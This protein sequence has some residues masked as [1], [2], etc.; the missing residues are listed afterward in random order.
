MKIKIEQ[1]ALCVVLVAGEME[2]K[3]QSKMKKNQR[4]TSTNN[5][6]LKCYVNKHQLVS[7]I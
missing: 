1:W 2:C 5:V 3:A 6:H 4:D 7:I